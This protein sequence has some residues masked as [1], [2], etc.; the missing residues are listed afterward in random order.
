MFQHRLGRDLCFNYIRGKEGGR[1]K[2]DLYFH[3]PVDG[4]Q[5]TDLCFM[6]SLRAE[7]GGGGGENVILISFLALS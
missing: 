5:E 3:H 2:G 6:D 7:G 1:K 4:G